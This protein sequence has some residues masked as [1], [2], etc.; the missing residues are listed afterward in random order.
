MRF[1]THTGIKASGVPEEEINKFKRL[2]KRFD[3]GS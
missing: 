1:R 2:Q 3:V